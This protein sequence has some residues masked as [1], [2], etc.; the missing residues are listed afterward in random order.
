MITRYTIQ[1]SEEWIEKY[2]KL[3]KTKGVEASKKAVVKY[4]EDPNRIALFGYLALPHYFRWEFKDCHYNLMNHI[5]IGKRHKSNKATMMYR[6]G[7]KTSIQVVLQCVYEA[8]YN[9]F[10]YVVINSYNVKMSID[11][12]RT[13]KE[14]FETN[15]FIRYFYGDPIGDKDYWNKQDITAFGRNRFVALSTGETARGLITKAVRPQKTLSDD[16]LSDKDVRSEDLRNETLDWYKKALGECLAS[17]GVQEILNTPLNQDDIIMTIFKK[18]PPFNHNWD[19]HKSPAM[20]KGKTVDPDWKTTEELEK[21]AE[22]EYTF[23]Q[24]MM[25]NPL[26]VESGMVKF[27]DLRFYVNLVKITQAVMHADITHT[28]KET[29]DY[30][31][32]G[33][34]G[35][36]EKNYLYLIDYII[37]KCEVDEQAAYVCS[38]YKRWFQKMQIDKVTYDEKGHASFGYWTKKAAI[39]DFNLSLPLESLKCPVDK[40]S[41]FKTHVPHF[42]GNR[43]YFPEE[44]NAE[45]EKLLLDQVLAFPQKGVHD[46]AVDMLS[47]CLDH[48]HGPTPNVDIG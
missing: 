8:C 23:Q 2:R 47:G 17:D 26:R 43:V 46:D 27:E 16:I 28:G 37:K 15:E 31:A 33:L 9:V 7:G 4:F 36:S 25:C 30:F 42:K 11:R 29:S 12:L 19:T 6:G 14:E 44:F 35:K 24:E 48:F 5:E 32:L 34:I 21:K 41:H 18:K 22:D 38:M 13:L 3:K 39:E 20:V 45:Y 10:Q 40:V 1:Q